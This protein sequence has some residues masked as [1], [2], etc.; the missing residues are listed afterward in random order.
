[1]KKLFGMIIGLL[2]IMGLQA[3]T[4]GTTYTL[5]A[6]VTWYSAFSHTHT[7]NYSATVLK[8]SIGGTDTKY[9][10]FAILKPKLY[11]YQF[12]VEYDTVLFQPAG[13]TVQRTVGNHVTVSLQGSIDG[14]YFVTLDTVLFHPTTMWL[15]AA[16]L[17]SPSLGVAT[18][19]DVTTGTLYRYLRI[20]AKGG[21][22]AKCSI[23]SKLAVKV[24]LRD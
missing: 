16:Q 7:T 23:I 9:W 19:K 22:A 14:T 12:L 2:L 11:F 5:P 6:N 15:P 8:D 20:S 4:S 3:Q 10:D 18:L 24:G 13:R 17:V 21:D 1:M